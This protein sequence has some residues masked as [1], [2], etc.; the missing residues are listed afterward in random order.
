LKKVT[1]NQC[2]PIVEYLLRGFLMD[3][4]AILD[5]YGKTVFELSGSRNRPATQPPFMG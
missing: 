1:L 3:T 2:Y 5:L 4:D